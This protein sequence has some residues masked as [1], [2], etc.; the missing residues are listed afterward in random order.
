[1]SGVRWFV[2]FC[3]VI[4]VQPLVF[5]AESSEKE[6]LVH[7]TLYYPP[8]WD[9]SEDGITGLHARLSDR[10][11]AQAGLDVDMESVPYAR[12]S[13]LLF[14]DDVAIIAY[15]ANPSTDHL[16]LFPI[17][18]TTIELRVYGLGS[19][20]VNNLEELEGK[21]IAIKRGFPLGSFEVIREDKKYHTVSMNSVEQAI[22]LLLIGRVDY[23]VTLADPFRKDIKKVA[24]GNRKIWSRTLET[25]DG[26]PI[27]I[28]KSHPRSDELYQKIKQA[29]GELLEAGEITYQNQ[30]TLLTEDFSG[31]P[32]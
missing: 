32:E 20:P 5:S 7:Y 1:M 31:N 16:L 9:K 23:I 10:L 17:P 13:Q 12:I 2:L 26:W 30:Q 25:L 3:L 18:K 27:A 22:Q 4:G 15:G 11:Y 8:Y 21:T 29:Y 24:L 6:A 28:V 19:E 14:P